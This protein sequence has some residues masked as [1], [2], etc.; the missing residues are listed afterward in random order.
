MGGVRVR[1]LQGWTNIWAFDE[2]SSG[3]PAKG[4]FDAPCT[5]AAEVEV[6]PSACETVSHSLE[7]VEFWLALFEAW[8]AAFAATPA[9][10]SNSSNNSAPVDSR[11]IVTNAMTTA[12]SKA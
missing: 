12:G 10:L 11:A 9:L 3:V 4:S 2:F 6:P 5:A 7:R 8:L 1:Q